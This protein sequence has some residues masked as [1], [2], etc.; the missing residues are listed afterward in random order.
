MALDF[1]TFFRKFLP[2]GDGLV[3][4]P[5]APESGGIIKRMRK[6]KAIYWPFLRF[7]ANGQPV[8]A[9][10]Y[11][12]DC[13]WDDSH[14]VYVKPNNEEATSKAVVYPDRPLVHLSRMK[15]GDG[16]ALTTFDPLQEGTFEVQHT[17]KTPNLKNTRILYT[18]YLG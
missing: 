3:P 9:S 4:T 1:L 18:V 10:P 7:D 17:M 12:L 13:R 14:V 2:P 6:Q 5:P 11:V 15:E 16:T 8:F